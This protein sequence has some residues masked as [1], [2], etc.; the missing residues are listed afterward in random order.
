MRITQ[1]MLILR[2]NFRKMESDFVLVKN[3][4]TYNSLAKNDGQNYKVN[5]KK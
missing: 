2:E 3:N 1:M 4:K 5:A